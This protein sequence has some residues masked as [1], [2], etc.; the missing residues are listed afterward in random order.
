[1]TGSPEDT[2]S[3]PKVPTMDRLPFG[4]CSDH[5]SLHYPQPRNL[6]S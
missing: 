3:L 6:A 1:L 5:R 2:G 4:L